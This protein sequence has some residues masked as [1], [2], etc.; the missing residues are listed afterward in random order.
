MLILLVLTV[1]QRGIGFFRSILVCRWLEPEALGQWDMAFG[2]LG[3]AAPLAVLG[4]PGSFGRY[5]ERYRQ[6]GQLKT[7]LR[8]TGLATLLGA[9]V[10]LALALSSV[11][12]FSELVFGS[13]DF[14]DL[15]LVL[16]LVLA[17]VIAHNTCTSLFTALR[18][19]RVVSLLQF[20]NTV[21]FAVLSLGLLYFWRNDAMSVVSAYGIACVLSAA[22]SALWL[23]R[24]WHGIPVSEEPLPRRD[25]WARLLP[26]AVWVWVTNWLANTFDVADRYM[27]VHYSGLSAPRR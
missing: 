18:M 1:V 4:L 2:F 17:A 8:R 10:V 26:F 6:R 16:S 13:R 7:F 9:L 27:I 23:S 22:G 15:M 12:W 5:V 20:V 11:G 25:M 3:L 19:Y 21:A 14:Q 24:A